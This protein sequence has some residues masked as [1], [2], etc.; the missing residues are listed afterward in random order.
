MAPL[1][2]RLLIVAA[3]A[4]LVAGLVFTV[5]QQLFLV[6]AILRAEALAPGAQAVP[7]GRMLRM[8]L[9]AVFNCLAAFGYG[10]LLAAGMLI[11]RHA[12]W[13]HG[14]AW[15]A[16]GWVSFALAPALGMPPELPGGTDLALGGR[17]LWWIWAAAGAAGGVTLLVFGRG[18]VSR[19]AGALLGTLPHLVSAPGAGWQGLPP[20]AHAFAIGVVG[21]AAAFWLTLGAATG[22]LLRRR[23]LP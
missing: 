19:L 23:R 21:A 18:W 11:R 1:F 10:L 6:P 22:Q 2:P 8:L 16:A 3:V 9:T 12:G 14:L 20:D 13:L 4:G 17:Q 15:G 5:L 7:E